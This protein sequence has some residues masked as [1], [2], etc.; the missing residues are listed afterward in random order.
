[1]SA[2]REVVTAGYFKR[3]RDVLVLMTTLSVTKSSRPIKQMLQ[4]F[5][6]PHM[7]F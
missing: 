6:K 1:M 4:G 5:H 7:P 2:Q 3:G